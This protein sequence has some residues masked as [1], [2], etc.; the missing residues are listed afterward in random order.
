MGNQPIK[1]AFDVAMSERL[2]MDVDLAKY[3]PQ[4]LAFAASAI[5]TYKT[6]ILPAV[7]FGDLYRLENPHTSPRSALDYVATD[8]AQAVV[9]ILQT[10]NAPARRVKPEGLD[11][12]KQYRVLELNLPQGVASSLPE[13]G[14]TI[15]G[16]TLMREGLFP[17]CAKQSESAVIELQSITGN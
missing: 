4:E 14:K 5:D 12:G 13:N 16:A 8:R 9:F 3:S 10:S 6:R 17:Q 1:F 2:G 15:D 11:P 7:Q